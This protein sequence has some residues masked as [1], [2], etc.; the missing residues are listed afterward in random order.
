MMGNYPDNNYWEWP[1]RSMS[2]VGTFIPTGTT[3]ETEIE[4]RIDGVGNHDLYRSM[5]GGQP[6]LC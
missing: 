3:F 2:S 6:F 5:K 1:R 4:S